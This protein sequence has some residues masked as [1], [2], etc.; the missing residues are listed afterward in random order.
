MDGDRLNLKVHPAFKKRTPNSTIPL[1]KDEHFP[2][3]TTALLNLWEILREYVG[4]D[5]VSGE[6]RLYLPGDGSSISAVL[7]EILPYCVSFFKLDLL[8]KILIQT[9]FLGCLRQSTG[10]NRLCR[11]PS[12]IQDSSL[13]PV[14]HGTH[15]Q[16]GTAPLP[17]LFTEY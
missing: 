2:L 16:K 13:G 7:K 5:F 1:P 14:P 10:E 6:P 11:K 15:R 17:G 12:R 3:L 9:L 4:L 8:S